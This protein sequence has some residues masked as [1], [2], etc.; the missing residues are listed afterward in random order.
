VSKTLWLLSLALR[1]GKT[2]GRQVE[3]DQV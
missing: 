3:W 1:Y 2:K